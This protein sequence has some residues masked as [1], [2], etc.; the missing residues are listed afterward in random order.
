MTTE[1]DQVDQF[2]EPA[3]WQIRGS[4]RHGGITYG[5]GEPVPSMTLAEALQYERM[6]QL[7]RVN[8]DGSVSDPKPTR[9]A[10]RTAE[11]YLRGRDEI[12]LRQILDFRPS[13]KLLQ[14]MLVLS[15][16]TARTQYLR[17]TLEAVC[18]YAGVKHPHA[19]PH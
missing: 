1:Q 2:I 11:E 13:K 6:A 15:K 7:V 19:D 5:R 8:A 3:E 17:M 12:V 10:P 16:Q 14:E 18:L 4:L 9:P